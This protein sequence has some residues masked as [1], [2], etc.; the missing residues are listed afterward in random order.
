MGNISR[1]DKAA[2]DYLIVVGI[3]RLLLIMDLLVQTDLHHCD[4]AGENS[5]PGVER[6]HSLNYA[7]NP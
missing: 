5:N 4:L 7:V 6:G 3:G 1:R 2:V